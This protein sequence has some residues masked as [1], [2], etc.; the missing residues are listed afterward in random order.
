MFGSMTRK[1]TTALTRAGTLSRVMTSCGGMVSVTARGRPG[2]SARSR[3]QEHQPGP[4]EGAQPAQPEADAPLVLRDTRDRAPPPR[5]DDQPTTRP[6]I[7]RA[8]TVFEMSSFPA[9]AQLVATD[10]VG[11]S[12]SPACC[13]MCSG[14]PAGR[15]PQVPGKRHA[16]SGTTSDRRR[17][18]SRSVGAGPGHQHAQ[19]QEMPISARST[20]CPRWNRAGLRVRPRVDRA[21]HL[22]AVRSTSCSCA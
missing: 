12:A 19:R 7:R 10:L 9:E 11:G 6:T 4:G 20:R 18:T 3:Q 14:K 17:S 13:G 16:A 5:Q 22:P 2:S 21:A 1:S 15:A 8:M